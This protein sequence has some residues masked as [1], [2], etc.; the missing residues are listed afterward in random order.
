MLNN[1]TKC[2][3]FSVKQQLHGPYSLLISSVFGDDA[4]VDKL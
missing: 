4:G 3:Y 2:L 1:L